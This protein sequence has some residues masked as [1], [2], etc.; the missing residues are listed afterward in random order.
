M[1]GTG[2]DTRGR[3]HPWVLS[4]GV[5]SDA[6]DLVARL[7]ARGVRMTAPRRAVL[8]ALARSGSHVSADELHALVH[9]GHPDVNLSTVYRTMDLLADAGIVDHVHLGHG[10]A[11]YHLVG[12]DHGHLVCNE[13]GAVVELTGEVGEGIVATVADRL[14]FHLDL[15]HFA[16]TGWCTGC[17]PSD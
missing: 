5:G 12:D 10:P 14:G 17:R 7:R 4:S 1:G 11:E 16:L 13:C 6:D 3:R 8:Q 2:A 9:A 15:R